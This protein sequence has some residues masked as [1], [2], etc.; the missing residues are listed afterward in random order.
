MVSIAT[1][2]MLII[3]LIYL[4][5]LLRVSIA[6]FWENESI[7]TPLLLGLGLVFIA[8]LLSFINIGIIDDPIPLSINITGALIPLAISI[9]II[10]SKRVNFIPALA[11]ILIVTP[12]A[13]FLAS[14]TSKAISIDTVLWFL[15]VAVSGVLGYFWA[16]DKESLSSASLTYLA[17]S[18]GMLIGGD[19]A[20]IPTFISVGGQSLILGGGGLMDFVFLAGPFSIAM[21]WSVQGIWAFL[22]KHRVQTLIPKRGW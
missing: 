22:K 7:E 6:D 10:A 19:L 13:Y 5:R 15:P 21:L 3:L 4:Q 18:M 17:A 9:Y 11:S 2:L 16:K 14:I 1:A 12:V 20:R 8:I